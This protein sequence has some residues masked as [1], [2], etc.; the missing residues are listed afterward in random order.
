MA[1]DWTH[2]GHDPY[3]GTYEAAVARL[4][5]PAALGSV[6]RNTMP[7]DVI[8][9]GRDRITAMRGTAAN[10]R[11]MH[12]GRDKLCAGPVDRSRW[13]NGHT[14]KANVYC[15][16][17]TTL[18]V[19]VP[20]V[21]SNVSRIDYRPSPRATARRAIEL[22]DIDPGA[23]PAMRKSATLSDLLTTVAAAGPSNQAAMQGR[24]PGLPL[25]PAPWLPAEAKT[26]GDG[27]EKAP[28]NHVPEPG[29]AWLVLAGLA[30][31]AGL[32]RGALFGA[33]TSI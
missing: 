31:L 30:S 16:P 14:E 26:T 8:V 24:A 11:D 9:I 20:L 32:R 19:A 12:F 22:M 23:S 21:C 3:H 13:P 5:L 27:G 1:C 18:C 29:A 17:G 2:P 6:I 7:T 10:L 4:G 28:P 15:L 33:E 25:W